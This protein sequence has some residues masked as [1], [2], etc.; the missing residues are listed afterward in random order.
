MNADL[1][2]DPLPIAHGHGTTHIADLGAVEQKCL[3]AGVLFGE[4]LKNSAEAL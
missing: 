2:E 4:D 1:K 3:V